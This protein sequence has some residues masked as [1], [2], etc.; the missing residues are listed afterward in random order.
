MACGFATLVL[1]P[2]ALALGTLAGVCI[3]AA[4]AAALALHLALDALT[5]ALLAA[6]IFAIPWNLAHAPALKHA[7]DEK[8]QDFQGGFCAALIDKTMPIHLL[9]WKQA[10]LLLLDVALLP[11]VHWW[12][13]GLLLTPIGWILE[14]RIGG[15]CCRPS[16]F[17][18]GAPAEHLLRVSNEMFDVKDWKTEWRT[19]HRRGMALC[20]ACVLLVLDV[21]ST[22]LFLLHALFPWLLTLGSPLWK[23][24]A[25]GA[26]DGLEQARL[27]EEK[28]KRQEQLAAQAE[29]REQLR[30]ELTV[31]SRRQ[32]ESSKRV[33]VLARRP[34]AHGELCIS[35]GSV[36][37]FG[38]HTDWEPP[39]MAIVNA[40]N[41]GGLGGGGVD[42]A[43]T[44][45]G[46]RA[47]ASDRQAL[48]TLSGS[49]YGDR[50]RTGGAVLTGPNRYMPPG[51][52]LFCANVIHAVGPDYRMVRGPLEEG[53]R[54]LTSAYAES[55]AVA[56]ENGIEYIGFS[57][58]SAGIFR[59][60][61]ELDDVLRISLQ[62]VRAN[63]YPGLKEVH[64]VAFSPKEQDLLQR[65][66]D[67]PI[68][69]L[70][71][72]EPQPEP[73][74]EPDAEE[75]DQVGHI[76]VV[77]KEQE[78]PSGGN[79]FKLSIQPDADIAGLKGL[80][81]KHKTEL[82]P[83]GQ[84]LLLNG[85]PLED[86]TQKLRV[87]KIGEG[88][89]LV[90]VCQDAAEGRKLREAREAEHE[91]AARAREAAREEAAR[92]AAM[93]KKYDNCWL[94]D[95][96][97]GLPAWFGVV[98][99]LIVALQTFGYP[100]FAAWTLL[101]ACL[102]ALIKVLASCTTEEELEAQQECILFANCSGL[103]SSDDSPWTTVLTDSVSI[104]CFTGEA[105]ADAWVGW[106]LCAPWLAVVVS[107]LIQTW[108]HCH[109]EVRLF[110]FVATY[111]TAFDPLLGH[112]LLLPFKILAVVLTPIDWLVSL[113]MW[114]LSRPS[115]PLGFVKED[116]KP[117]WDADKPCSWSIRTVHNRGAALLAGCVLLLLD[118]GST[119]LC[120]V[121]LLFPV[122]FTLASPLWKRCCGEKL[123][124]LDDTPESCPLCATRASMIFLQIVGL[125]LFLVWGAVLVCMIPA[126]I[127]IH[128]LL[129]CP[130][131]GGSGSLADSEDWLTARWERAE[132]CISK[133]VSFNTE[134]ARRNDYYWVGLLLFLP[135]LATMA[136]SLEQAW[137]YAGEQ[138]PLFAPFK[139][140][141]LACSSCSCSRSREGRHAPS[142]PSKPQPQ[143]EPE[144]EPQ[145]GPEPE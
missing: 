17:L 15:A 9:V 125:P 109:D 81:H 12:L 64:L 102:P 42:G 106:I 13:L 22:V 5:L 29:R 35:A 34:L 85:S 99:V 110:N 144:P 58:L 101:W 87:C 47:L 115:K 23:K 26:L 143:P 43:I 91:E 129:V 145:P 68:P 72:A 111:S 79:T 103:L 135:W 48:P 1:G 53:D 84:R 71:T 77:I 21:L 116:L 20:A 82:E 30:K 121:H 105:I 39:L 10:G 59:R 62:A 141:G 127:F 138:M 37:D 118:L 104:D 86:E 67:E 16:A 6:V 31:P 65:L 74:P 19:A 46:G 61:R 49:R 108:G 18:T 113:R 76:T 50:I 117:I 130:D 24:A 4:I 27:A 33:E 124:K 60:P 134:A 98:H 94:G 40:A 41:T 45:A 120:G 112:L 139:A 38:G 63:S 128:V 28:R 44:R 11:I 126:P 133:D 56:A 119:V 132:Y 123:S 52:Q 136:S 73:Q 51:G 75:A 140:L 57:L 100:I 70:P 32:K 92:V 83:D 80:I 114:C 122:V 131:D 69:S 90:L 88:T 107:S 66:L 25:A 36:L 54:L 8:L 95:F 96:T 7:V 78:S 93:V 2:I 3:A 142:Q 97:P 137:F 55:M 14:L 89:E